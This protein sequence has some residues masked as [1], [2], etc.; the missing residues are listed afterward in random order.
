MPLKLLGVCVCVGGANKK[1]FF[2]L[3]VRFGGI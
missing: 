1:L 2:K 3:F